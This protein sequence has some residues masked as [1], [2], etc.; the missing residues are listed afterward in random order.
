MTSAMLFLLLSAHAAEPEEELTV[1]VINDRASRYA[2][3]ITVLDEDDFT[4]DAPISLGDVLR[5]APGVH[6][7]DEDGA[8]LRANIGMRGLPPARSSKVLVLEDGL[9]VSPG[10]YGHPELYYS[11]AVERA[12]AVEILRGSGSIRFGPQTLAGV[13]NVVGRSAP[14]DGPVAEAEARAGTLGLWYGRAA[15]GA[16]T[17]DI[18]WRLDAFHKRYDGPRGVALVGTD[19][20][21]RLDANV[22]AGRLWVK[23]GAWLETSRPSYLGL[24]TPQF[25]SDPT[26]S[27]AINDHFDM[28]RYA[29]SASYRVRLGPRLVQ[30]TSA[31]AYTI[32]RAW[33]RQ[34]Y[35]RS[36]AG[37]AYERVVPGAP[38]A[39]PDDEGGTLYFLDAN[40]IRDRRYD[41]AGVQ[42]EL[43]WDGGTGGV[44]ATVRAGA[45]LHHEAELERQYAGQRADAEVGVLTSDQLRS[46]EAVAAWVLADLWFADRVRLD[47]G[48]RTESFWSTR[49]VRWAETEA[50]YGDPAMEANAWHGGLLPG[51]GLGVRATPGLFVYTGLHRGWSPPQTADAIT[52]EG[53]VLELQ[54]ES[55]WNAEIG[56][57]VR[58]SRGAGV[59]LTTF[60]LLFENQVSA[61]SEA[62]VASADAVVN[63]NP[64]RHLGVELAPWVD[65]GALLGSDTSVKLQAAWTFTDARFTAGELAGN[66]LPYAPAHL[67]HAEATLRTPVG[68]GAGLGFDA[69]SSQYADAANTVAATA[70]GT[71]GRLPGWNSL[72]ANL[73]WTLRDKRER[74]LRAYVVAKNLL[75]QPFIVSRAPAGIQPG[76]FRTVQVG[77]EGEL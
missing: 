12:A 10:P 30:R 57:H 9:P 51:V 15:V 23:A 25:A 41:V 66:T 49:A 73:S 71:N 19:L 13:V 45:R 1:E 40:T 42:D 24:T 33:G 17:P 3:S 74:S 58:H 48:V 6:V 72:G 20:A 63:G 7:L 28:D 54:A 76:G 46:G 16:G 26:G 62:G 21:G 35:D 14:T 65:I 77:L 53:T 43:V 2:G 4:A 55:S 18:G 75:D 22:G 8:G 59:D 36:D 34:S 11:P 67:V 64:T 39:A 27:H 50:G 56:A 31:Y 44:Q 70:D 47:A 69:V 32:G 52:D 61:P 29:L 37:E 5:E 38:G 60:Y 68:F